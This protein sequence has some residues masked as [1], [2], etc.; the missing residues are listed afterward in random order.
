MIRPRRKPCCGGGSRRLPPKDFCGQLSISTGVRLVKFGE[1]WTIQADVGSKTQDLGIAI[2]AHK[3][4]DTA[5]VRLAEV[6]LHALSRAVQADKGS[7]LDYK[8]GRK[9][10]LIL[11]K[12]FLF[13]TVGVC[14]S[15]KGR[16]CSA[17]NR[18]GV[19]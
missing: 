5:G 10:P 4:R 13:K 11:L 19:L 1:A 7:A 12:D 6:T 9:I 8:R 16:G 17:C 3:C 14:S 15:C 2:S 18:M